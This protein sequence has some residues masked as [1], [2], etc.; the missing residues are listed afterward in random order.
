M[1]KV[2]IV[3]RCS[4]FCSQCGQEN[5]NMSIADAFGMKFEAPKT[6]PLV[7]DV[8][9]KFTVEGMIRDGP[10]VAWG[11][12]AIPKELYYKAFDELSP[13]E[14][15]IVNKAACDTY[16]DSDAKKP[17]LFN[18][19]TIVLKEEVSGTTFGAIRKT[20]EGKE[21]VA[22]GS[23]FFRFY[24]DPDTGEEKIPRAFTEFIVARLG[25][26]FTPGSTISMGDVFTPGMKMVAC[27]KD[28]RNDYKAINQDTLVKEGIKMPD[29]AT[30]KKGAKP[31]KA[32][33]TESNVSDDASAMLNTI[34]QMRGKKVSLLMDMIQSGKFGAPDTAMATLN[35]I[36]AKGIIIAN[37][38]VLEYQ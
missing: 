19:Y 14:K 28:G 30:A 26:N 17:K 6:T 1:G 10:F 15:D 18:R 24:I 29:P 12:T 21:F 7:N 4:M 13:E 20:K 32:T 27:L 23:A 38:D 8:P 22:D 16:P 5:K 33:T 37:G 25:Y 34:K 11:T 35:E 2:F 31:K 9:Y 3:E 36:K